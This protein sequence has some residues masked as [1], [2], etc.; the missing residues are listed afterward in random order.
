MKRI[1]LLLSLTLIFALLGFIVAG[2]GVSSGFN[3]PESPD[4]PDDDDS[5]SD[6]I[7]GTWTGTWCSYG[8]SAMSGNV[9]EVVF[10]PSS[11]QEAQTKGTF[12]GT[13]KITGMDGISTGSVSGSINSSVLEFTVVFDGTD[14]TAEFEGTKI[15]SSANGSY[16]MYANGEETDYGTFLINKNE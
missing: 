8:D 6:E 10:T 12:T 1:K 15:G 2:C 4:F 3:Y 16:H 9:E 5:S 11:A 13:L 14:R 7:S